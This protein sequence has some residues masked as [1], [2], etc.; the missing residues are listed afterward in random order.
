MTDRQVSLGEFILVSELLE[1]AYAGPM[2]LPDYIAHKCELAEG[3][4][5]KLGARCGRT[6]DAVLAKLFALTHAAS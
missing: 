1:K 2:P 3:A 5:A 6:G 4:L